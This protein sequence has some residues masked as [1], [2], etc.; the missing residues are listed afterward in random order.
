MRNTQEKRA[1]AAAL[2]GNG[3]FGFSFMA[4]KIA[5]QEAEPMV[6]LGFRFLLAF[7]VMNLILLSGKEKICLKGKPVGMLLLLG[8]FEPILY[9]VF[10][11][12]GIKWT[13]SAFSGVM[14]AMIPVVSMFFAA[15]FLGEIP[16]G[17]QIA[18]ALLS[19]CGVALVSC[20]GEAQ[21]VIQLAV[22]WY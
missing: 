9:F 21:G 22:S 14:I 19:V 8:M 2:L 7:L 11:S 17:R 10:E 6:L 12:Y 5:L 16:K 15:G 13:T 18:F 3:I 20:S 4:S 1:V